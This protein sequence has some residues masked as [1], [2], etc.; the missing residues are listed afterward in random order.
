M[1]VLFESSAGYGLFKCSDK[2]KSCSKDDVHST[3]FTDSKSAA[4]NFKL[5]VFSEFADTSDAVAAAT[6][7][8]EGKLTSGLKKFLKKNVK[9]DELMVMDR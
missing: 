6:A 3:Y 5:Q 7:A 9:D 1:L 8:I 2:V 4:K